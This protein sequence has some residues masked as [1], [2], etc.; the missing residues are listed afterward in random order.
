MTES[1]C[2]LDTNLWVYL[3][4]TDPKAETVERLIQTHFD[5]RLD[6]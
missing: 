1:E 4:S 6:V 3:Y 2:F 5:V